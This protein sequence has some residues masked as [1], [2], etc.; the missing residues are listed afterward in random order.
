MRYF[1]IALAVVGII[2][3]IVLILLLLCRLRKRR[4]RKKVCRLSTEEKCRSLN[5]ALTPFGFCY[6]AGDDSIGVQMYPWQREMGYCRAY[7]EAA[8]AMYMVIDCEPVYFNYAGQRYLIEFWKGQYGC[9]TGAEIGIYVNRSGDFERPAA[10]LFYECVKDEE[11]QP[12]SF[13]LIRN[14]KIVLRRSAVHWWLT[15]FRVGMFS[16]PQELRLEASVGFPTVGMARAFY[17][18]MLR[19]G[20]EPEE[21]HMEKCTVSFVFDKPRT[22]QSY[23]YPNWYRRCIMRRNRKNCRC[24]CRITKC[25]STTLDRISFLGY[26]FPL[27]YRLMIRMGTKCRPRRYCRYKRKMEK[28]G[29]ES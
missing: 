6:E 16:Q 20:Y 23:R 27:L 13:A 15:G 2:L 5:K 29:A 22:K 17:D 24:Y 12:M 1:Y 9:T 7:D 11:R 3:L 10:D 14:G 4:A 8:I 26:C 25:F 21:I 19:A 28:N 18:G